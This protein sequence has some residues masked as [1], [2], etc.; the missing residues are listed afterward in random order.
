MKR[1]IL[2]VLIFISTSLTLRAQCPDNTGPYP[3]PAGCAWST[4]SG[5]FSY[6]ACH[7]TVKYCWR[8]C[9]D[10]LQVWT[11]EIDEDYTYGNWCD[12]ADP[13]WMIWK[14]NSDAWQHAVNDYEGGSFS[15]VHHWIPK[16]DSSFIIT[17]SFMPGCW[18]YSSSP[19]SGKKYIACSAF[20]GCRCTRTCQLCCDWR[21]PSGVCAG[22]IISNC[23][24]TGA[25]GCSCY[26]TPPHGTLWP[27]DWCI[28]V[29]CEPS[30]GQ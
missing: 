9:N 13:V 5:D 26:A 18:K 3:D 14:A 25:T 21:L 20:D 1:V 7:G 29:P 22:W 23:T 30:G 12:T 19:Q 17:S 16:C 6:G 4:G 15:G 24:N 10:T 28:S 11:Y 2:L 8:Y 27:T